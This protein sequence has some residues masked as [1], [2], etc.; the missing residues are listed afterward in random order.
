MPSLLQLP[1]EILYLIAGELDLRSLLDF[2]LASIHLNDIALPAILERRFETRYVMLQQ[3]SIENLIEI[4]RHPVYGPALK[5]LAICIDHLTQFPEYNHVL[6]RWGD[7]IRMH[8]EGDLT[9][10]VTDQRIRIDGE[11]VVVN[12]PTYDRL[13]EDQKYMMASGLNTTYLAQAMAAFPNLETI[14]FDDGFKPWGATAL[15]RQ[16]GVPMVNSIA[17][18]DSIEFVT[19]TLRAI[20]IA[21]VTSNISLF[22]LDLAVGQLYHGISP[23]MLVFPR[24]VLRYIQSHPINLTSLCLSVYPRNTTPPKDEQVDDILRFIAL[25]SGLKRLA[26]GFCQR[27]RNEYLPLISQKLRIPGLQFLCIY[28]IDCTEG[29][30]AT[31]LL[32]HRD[33]LEE[34]EF[35]TVNIIPGGGTWQSLLATVRDELTVQVLSMT[36]CM[37]VERRVSC[38][39]GESDD[40]SYLDAFEIS[41]TRQDWA[42]AIHNIVIR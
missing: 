31:L 6:P 37:L 23:D 14:I 26:L 19:Q 18:R 9:S 4:S 38:R 29:E 33:S 24:P 34:V 39:A 16:T 20:I 42:D 12:R 5:H 2:R 11:E 3:D 13:L 8:R 35:S 1:N 25:F 28:S 17:A 30:L 36:D 22:E 7:T 41:G 32:G 40:A 15:E 10:R 27:H 21:I